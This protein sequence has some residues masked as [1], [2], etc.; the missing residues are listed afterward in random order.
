VSA[1]GDLTAEEL[2]DIF[3]ASNDESLDEDDDDDHAR[4]GL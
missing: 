3:G 4:H 2:E 1:D